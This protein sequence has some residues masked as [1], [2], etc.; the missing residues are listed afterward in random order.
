MLQ[1]ARWSVV[2]LEMGD[3]ED[4]TVDTVAVGRV[5]GRFRGAF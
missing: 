4:D 1:R 5:V 2:W 3:C